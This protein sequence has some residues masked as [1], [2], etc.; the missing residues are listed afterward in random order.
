MARSTGP[1]ALEL[2]GAFEHPGARPL[3]G[4]KRRGNQ[5]GFAASQVR[6]SRG[7]AHLSGRERRRA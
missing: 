1:A 6:F 4:G 3:S 5:R 2:C 7:W